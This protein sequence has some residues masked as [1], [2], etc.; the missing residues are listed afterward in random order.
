[1]N[2]CHVLN[3]VGNG[4]AEMITLEM[5]RNTPREDVSYTVCYLGGD[6]SLAPE[7]KA[8]GARVVSLGS[9]T[10]PPQLDPSVVPKF[11][12]MIRRN[13]FD[14]LHAHMP[15][16]QMLSRATARVVGDT[17]VVS[18][19][20][21]TRESLPSVSRKGFAVTETLDSAT[22]A[23]SRAVQ[24]SFTG[25]SN[26]YQENG[27]DERWGTIHNGIDVATFNERVR[28]APELP[29]LDAEGPIFLNV[30]RYIP[31]KGQRYLIEAMDHVVD[32]L[33]DATAVTVGYGPLEEEL[34]T[35]TAERG[36]EDN[37]TVLGRDPAI[38]KYYRLADAF[39]FS[40]LSEGLPVTGIEAMAAELPVVGTRV[41][42]VQ[43]VVDDGVTGT[44]VPP[45]SPEELAEAMIE[46]ESERVRRKFGQRGYERATNRFA[47][48]KTI[49]GYLDLYDELLE[50][51]RRERVA[52]R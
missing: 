29:E 1:M 33:P 10:K 49:E 39:V 3:N 48:E 31:Q 11:F 25:R 34:R 9:R 38:H 46:M 41:S 18:T 27:L 21:T 37:V 30:G 51:E 2:V 36:L 52:P 45:K 20:H 24:R 50:S 32:A 19:Q 40:S 13:D 23:V 28:E 7:M 44:L 12:A 8:T 17:E 43:E 14:V 16:V 47:I 42:G 5:V 26:L 4:G 15:Y 6:H 35:A 22:I